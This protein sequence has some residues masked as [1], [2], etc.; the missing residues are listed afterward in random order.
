LWFSNILNFTLDVNSRAHHNIQYLPAFSVTDMTNTTTTAT[1][2]ANS[3]ASC[4]IMRLPPELRQMIYS[5]YL[6][7][8][9][10]PEK[11]NVQYS[12]T[13]SLLR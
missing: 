5:Y 1:S 2:L 7:D 9:E 8:R 4:P 6:S 11:V 3:S 10:P 12:T 13:P